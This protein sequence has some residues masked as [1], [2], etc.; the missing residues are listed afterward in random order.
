MAVPRRWT[1]IL[2]SC[3]NI[4]ASGASCNM[5]TS[6]KILEGGGDSFKMV[7]YTEDF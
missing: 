5:Q 4:T 3:A 6:I 1:N 7:E 2:A